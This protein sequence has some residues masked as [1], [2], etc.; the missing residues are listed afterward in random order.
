MHVKGA[1]HVALGHKKKQM[2]TLTR[3]ETFCAVLEE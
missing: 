2:R 1:E 3:A